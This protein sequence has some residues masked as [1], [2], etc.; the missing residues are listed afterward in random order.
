[1]SVVRH[2]HSKIHRAGRV[3]LT[4]HFLNLVF[5]SP[6]SNELETRSCLA[7]ENYQLGHKFDTRDARS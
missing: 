7:L 1:M 3:P 4:V 5:D 2:P 6:N